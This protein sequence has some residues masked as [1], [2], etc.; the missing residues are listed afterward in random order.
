MD[1]VLREMDWRPGVYSFSCVPVS[2]NQMTVLVS[3][4]CEGVCLHEGICPISG[5]KHVR[6]SYLPASAP[7]SVP[8]YHIWSMT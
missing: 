6:M 8:G 7:C 1:S 4:S 3:G 2:S 5:E